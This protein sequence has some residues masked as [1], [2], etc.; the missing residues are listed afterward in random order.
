MKRSQVQAAARRL[1]LM[2]TL[3]IVAAPT[4][5]AH[6]ADVD[7]GAERLL[8]RMTDYMASLQQFSVATQNTLEAVLASGQKI[9]FVMNASVTVQRP[10]KLRAERKGDL[11]SQVFFYD[12]KKLTLYDP[13]NKVYAT[14]GAPDTIEG[15]LDFARDRLDIIAPAGDFLYRN[16]FDLLMEATTSGFVVGNA[17]IGGVKCDHLAFR[18]ADVDWQVWIAADGKPLPRRYVVT[19][20]DVPS[21]PT[22]TA[23]MTNWN[24]AP[25]VSDA[26]FNFVPPTGVQAVDFLTR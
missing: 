15:M 22:F 1:F 24:T 11:V 7:A 2:V 4:L 26:Q 25:K 9:Q 19:T 21:Y 8:R 3:V 13:K 20:R 6:A 23:V 16:A 14:V 18:G 5:P 10:N 12:G 17:V